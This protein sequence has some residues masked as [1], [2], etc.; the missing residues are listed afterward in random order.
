VDFGNEEAVTMNR[1]SECPD[2]LQ[3][4]PWQSVQI[5]LARIQLTADDRETGK[6]LLPIAKISD[7]KSYASQMFEAKSDLT[8]LSTKEILLLDYKICM[9][10][11]EQ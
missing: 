7:V 1:L 11:G 9:F 10:N 6:Y 2:N 4:I 8:G 5:K 3:A